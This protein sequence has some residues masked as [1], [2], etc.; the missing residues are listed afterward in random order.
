MPSHKLTKAA[1]MLN[2][3]FQVQRLVHTLIIAVMGRKGGVTKTT[4]AVNLAVALARIYGL[5]VCLIDADGQGDSG[6]SVGLAQADA[7]HHLILGDAE[8]SQRGILAPMPESFTGKG[9]SIPMLRASDL[10]LDVERNPATPS[11]MYERFK[12]LNGV[13]D[14][15]VIDAGPNLA[16]THIGLYYSMTDGG[17]HIILPTLVERKSI[18]AVGR[19]FGYLDQARSVSNLPVAE[20]LAVQPNRFQANWRIQHELL[21]YIKGK[22]EHLAPVMA[23]MQNLAVWEYASTMNQSIY[24]ASGPYASRAQRQF[25][26]L[27]DLVAAKYYEQQK[28]A[29]AS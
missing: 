8:W 19:M 22:Y 12:E 3:P 28:E 4:V 26:P 15:V 10:Q 9:I 13:Y 27:V 11:L 2:A 24:E 14:V 7:F 17:T 25:R 21:G 18:D 16:E 20:V 5:S 29:V 6:N 23:P 1:T